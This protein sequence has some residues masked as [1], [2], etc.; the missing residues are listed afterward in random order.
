MPKEILFPLSFCKSV[1]QELAPLFLFISHTWNRVGGSSQF[2][3]LMKEIACVFTR[4]C[5]RGGGRV[6]ASLCVFVHICEHVYHCADMNM[7]AWA[8]ASDVTVHAHM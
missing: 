8:H 1:K 7:H 4:V 6:H 3:W 5:A 2:L